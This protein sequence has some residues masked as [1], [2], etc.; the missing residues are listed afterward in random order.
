MTTVMTAV[1]KERALALKA[2]FNN[3]QSS[4]TN[5]CSAEQHLSNKVK[6]LHSTWAHLQQ[7][8]GGGETTL[9]L[10]EVPL[11]TLKD[12]GSLKANITD[13]K[14]PGIKTTV[15]WQTSVGCLHVI[16][17]DVHN[18]SNRT[19][20]CCTLSLVPHSTMTEAQGMASVSKWLP[21]VSSDNTDYTRTSET[22]SAKRLKLNPPITL[23]TMQQK[24]LPLRPGDRKTLTVS[25]DGEEVR[26][27]DGWRLWVFLTSREHVPTV[28]ESG[29]QMEGSH[30]ELTVCCGSVAMTTDDYLKG[31]YAIAPDLT[32]G[33]VRDPVIIQASLSAVQTCNTLVLTSAFTDLTHTAGII[34][35]QTHFQHATSLDCLCPVNCLPLQY[36]RIT[37]VCVLSQTKV[38]LCVWTR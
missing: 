3:L 4:T 20:H 2:L 8:S 22:H 35:A 38:C 16:G 10:P 24:E 1:V 13:P 30:R 19:L 21:H 11:S 7:L 31:T 27:Q 9:P 33:S 26:V 12:D 23:P 36:V 14:L 15:S 37:S 34:E 5:L 29:D 32:S 28:S 17:V 6:F 18:G 25:F